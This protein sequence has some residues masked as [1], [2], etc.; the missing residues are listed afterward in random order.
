MLLVGDQFVDVAIRSAEV[1]PRRTRLADE[2]DAG[3]SKLTDGRGQVIDREAGD[4][5]GV[6]VIF[7]G[8][9]RAKYFDMAAVR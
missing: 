3:I 1:L 9:V 6:E 8:V 5:A 2:G 7:A 4:R